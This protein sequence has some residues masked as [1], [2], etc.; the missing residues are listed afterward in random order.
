MVRL[1]CASHLLKT[2][3]AAAWLTT[4]VGARAESWQP[5]DSSY[6]WRFPEDHWSHAGYQTE[7]WYLTAQLEDVDDPAA[8]FGMQFTIFRIGLT[9]GPAAPGSA[10]SARDLIMGH[11]AIGDFAAGEHHFS[12]L[13]YRASPLLAGFGAYPDTLIA[14]SRAPAGT[15]GRWTLEWNGEAFTVSMA[16]SAQGMA[17]RLETRPLKPLVLQGPNG[18][19]RKGAG[20]SSASQ[21]YSFTRLALEGRLRVGGREHRVR[22]EGWFDKE[23]GSN[24]LEPQQAG[25]DWFSLQLADGRELML[26]QLRDR[27]GRPDWRRGTLVAADGGV[28]YLGPSDWQVEAAGSW[29]SSATGTRYP[30]RWRVAV[31]GAQLELEVLPRLAA[32]ENVGPRSGFNYW[33][34]AV[35]LR[36]AD[37]TPRGQGYVELVGLGG[38]RPLTF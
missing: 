3:L 8:R 27:E 25:W 36:G 1:G 12:E 20:P 31:P 11:A 23:F 15:E 5:A 17:F 29:Q 7:W 18:Y 14:W 13:L 33:E 9:P 32:Q 22:G 30:E 38:G 6:A 26:Y 4:A 16:D 21:Y 34:G 24:Q 10:W 37:G 35:E 28:T 2:L 19:S